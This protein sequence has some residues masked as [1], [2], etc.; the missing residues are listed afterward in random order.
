[1]EL[2]TKTM[3]DLMNKMEVDAVDFANLLMIYV[4]DLMQVCVKVACEQTDLFNVLLEKEKEES[5]DEITIANLVI[6][7]IETL[8]NKGYEVKVDGNQNMEG[9]YE[10]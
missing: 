5:I 2:Y 1:M 7:L 4:A 10:A 3:L 8:K 6:S 9:K